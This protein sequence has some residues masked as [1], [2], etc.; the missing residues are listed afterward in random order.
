MGRA[1]RTADAITAFRHALAM[2]E[3]ESTTGRAEAYFGLAL[4]Q[5]VLGWTHTAAANYRK[6]LALKPDSGAAANN[7]GNVL[8]VQ[9]DHAGAL[10]CFRRACRLNPADHNAH[11]NWLQALQY[12]PDVTPGILF[13]AH[14]EWNRQH[15][16]PVYSR[17]KQRPHQN[18][19]LDGRPI[20]LGFVSPDLHHHAVGV[21]LLGALEALKPEHCHV[22]GYDTGVVE[23]AVSARLQAAAD[24]WVEAALL[25]DAC[26]AERVRADRIDVLFDL[27]GHTS[28][29][30]LLV[31]AR[32]PAPVQV[33]WL[34]YVG[35]TGLAAMDHILGDWYHCPQGYEP[36]HAEQVLRMDRSYLCFAPPADGPGPDEPVKPRP[37]EQN[38]F[39]TFGSFNNVAKI[40]PDVIAAWA[41]IVR[42]VPES[43]LV[44][45]S[46]GFDSPVARDLIHGLW[47]ASG[48]PPGQFATLRG[49][50]H[51]ELLNAYD[52]IDI[53]L[54]TFPYSGGLTT[55][56]ALWMGVP[57]VTFPGDT[58]AG[59]HSTSHLANLGLP[60]LIARDRADYV[61]LATLLARDGPWR[62][63]YA[64]LR[65]R[66]ARSALCD[67]PGWAR[68]FL[69]LM[70]GAFL[71]REQ[72]RCFSEGG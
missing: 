9:G 24:Q 26:L 54:D 4:T 55:L 37:C 43:R 40:T 63:S 22:T 20:K 13:S 47:Q 5:S 67:G 7:L 6:V 35:T 21:L 27:S 8:M 2:L 56:E 34:G 30:R 10:E 62:A 46:P 70:R 59:R 58:F 66:F 60:E 64:D 28:Q 1:G 33:S 31:F 48:G 39:V 17:S 29:N 57:V 11:S 61:K 44:L 42:G 23:D 41:E 12:G 18:P 50:G 71:R 25:D 38:G 65:R 36:Y 52:A 49:L 69:E 3:P 72:D 15:G 45:R 68:E 53:A 51:T 16:W 19:P 32:K 14:R